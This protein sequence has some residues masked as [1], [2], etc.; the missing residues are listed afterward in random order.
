M[1]Y[2]DLTGIEDATSGNKA[3]IKNLIHLFLNTIP[4]ELEVLKTNFEKSDWENLGLKAHKI[5]NTAISF[6]MKTVAEDLLFIE[7]NCRNATIDKKLFNEKM[8]N[9]IQL[10]ELAILGLQLEYNQL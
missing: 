8:N 7:T 3:Y 6:G 5:K 10:T 2:Y 9:I 1:K 4:C